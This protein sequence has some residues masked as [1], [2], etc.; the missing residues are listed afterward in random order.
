M[1]GPSLALQ[2]SPVRGRGMAASVGKQKGKHGRGGQSSPGGALSS[3]LKG[4]EHPELVWYHPPCHLPSRVVGPSRA[5]SNINSPLVRQA[6]QP[7]AA[8][9]HHGTQHPPHLLPAAGPGSSALGSPRAAPGAQ[10]SPG[11]RALTQSWGHLPTPHHPFL[12]HTGGGLCPAGGEP[13]PLCQRPFP[14]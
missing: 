4:E 7:A 11:I 13:A 2:P 8:P 3:L 12:T 14:R 6:A 1:P 10:H 9:S 5:P